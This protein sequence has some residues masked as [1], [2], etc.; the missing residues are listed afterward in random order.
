MPLKIGE[1][2]VSP[3]IVMLT[4]VQTTVLYEISTLKVTATPVD[5]HVCINVVGLDNV[6]VP[7]A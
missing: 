7:D 2:L 3:D 4:D 1:A 6:I 5:G